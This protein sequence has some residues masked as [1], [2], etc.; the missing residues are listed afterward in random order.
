M[1]ESVADVAER[2]LYTLT[3]RNL[4]TEAAAV[5][6]SLSDALKLASTWNAVLLIDEADVFLE[7]RGFRDLKE[8][9]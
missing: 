7:Q 4:G 5:E 9:V 1:I 3:A 8:T 6:Q 2:P